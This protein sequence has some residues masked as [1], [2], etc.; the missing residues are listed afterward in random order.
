MPC[1]FSNAGHRRL[2]REVAI[3]ASRLVTPNANVILSLR[4]YCSSQLEAMGLVQ[5]SFLFGGEATSGYH[6]HGIQDSS[7]AF[8]A[9]LE[10]FFDFI[11]SI[12]NTRLSKEG[13]LLKDL[14]KANAEKAVKLQVYNIKSQ[15]VRELEV[16]PGNMWGGQGLL[17]ASVRFCSF[18]GAAEN[19]WHVLDVEANSPAASAGL[20]AH[21]DFIVGADQLLQS[22]DDFFSLIEANEGKRL[23][24]LVYNT[25]S[26]RCREVVVMPNGAWGGEGSLGCGIGYGYLH[27]IPIRSLPAS[28]PPPE[29]D[30]KQGL[31]LSGSSL[32]EQHQCGNTQTVDSEALDTH[33]PNTVLTKDTNCSSVSANHGDGADDQCDVDSLSIPVRSPELDSKHQICEQVQVVGQNKEDGGT[34]KLPDIE[35]HQQQTLSFIPV[36]FIIPEERHVWEG[37][38]RR[39]RATSVRLDAAPTPTAS[40]TRVPLQ[41]EGLKMQEK[42]LWGQ[43]TLNLLL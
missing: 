23:K 12:G 33:Q 41:S 10:P 4:N 13:N 39:E 17:G 38:E 25:E 34:E 1:C 8:K 28:V 42:W 24:L 30:D 19:V 15:R 7:P 6:V 2:E 37:E 22:S 21:V 27:R 20:L 5:G 18:E 29:T 43:M 26:E 36:L 35:H 14:L 16:T 9:G 40:Q 11:I 31:L 32:S 3:L